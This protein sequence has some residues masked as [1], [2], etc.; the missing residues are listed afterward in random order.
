MPVRHNAQES[1]N[2]ATPAP[3]KRLE[4]SIREKDKTKALGLLAI[5]HL[6]KGKNLKRS[7][8]LLQMD[9][10]TIYRL[11]QRWNEKGLEGLED[12]EKKWSKT[13]YRRGNLA[14]NSGAS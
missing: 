9:K 8:G 3:W 4:N 2:S 1:R 14:K 5:Y 10:S 6:M 7:C 13:S 12:L 11:I